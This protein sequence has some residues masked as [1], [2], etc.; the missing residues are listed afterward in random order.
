MVESNTGC[1]AS[2]VGS[3]WGTGGGGSGAGKSGS[4]DWAG[5][6]TTGGIS[7]RGVEGDSNRSSVGSGGEKMLSCS[8]G[9]WRLNSM[10]GWR[11]MGCGG[12]GGEGGGAAIGATTTCWQ[13]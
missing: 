5:A 7:R 2:T 12:A 8:P 9:W 6:V 3:I 11:N 13:C 1:G 10:V 4:G